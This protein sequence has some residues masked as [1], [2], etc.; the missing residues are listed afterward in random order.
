MMEPGA[1]HA[2]FNGLEDDSGVVVGD[3]VGIAVLRLVHFQVGML[4]RELLAGVNGLQG[5]GRWGGHRGCQRGHQRGPEAR[6]A[7]PSSPHTPGRA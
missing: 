4:P 2:T 7:G 1:P 3:D 5:T 6:E